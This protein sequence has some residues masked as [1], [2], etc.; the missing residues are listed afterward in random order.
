MARHARITADYLHVIVRGNGKKIIFED[1]IDRKYYLKLLHKFS[2]E[3]GISI[4]AYCLMDNHVH[5]LI[6]DA[7]GEIALFMKKLNVSYAGYY[8]DRYDHV[9]HLF[10]G[11]YKSEN[12]YDERYLLAV[13]RYILKNPE[14]A[15]IASAREYRWNSYLDFGKQ[16]R[17]TDTALFVSLF[18]SISAFDS[19]MA[20]KD[21]EIY[22]EFE[23]QKR[24]DAWAHDV[25]CEV[26]HVS[27]GKELLSME[28]SVRNQAIQL[29][30][31]Q[32]ISIRQIE[33]L[34]GIS[35]STIQRA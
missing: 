32:G 11:R 24:D 1:N 35:R 15:G 4:L 30:K 20:E 33:R 5:L 13:Y 8:N 7:D 25:L 6:H 17:L 27:S 23:P 26:L 10:Q 21:E 16:K 3:L 28:K 34:T 31:D 18:G 29:L 19:F 14:K 2:E 9:G 12:I 22:M